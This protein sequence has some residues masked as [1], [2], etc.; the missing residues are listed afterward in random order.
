[1]TCLT[2]GAQFL[3]PAVGEPTR[4]ALKSRLS[5]DTITG[6][7]FLKKT[8][9]SRTLKRIMYWFPKQ[10]VIDGFLQISSFSVDLAYSGRG[11]GLQVHFPNPF[12]NLHLCCRGPCVKA[13]HTLEIPVTEA[14][15]ALGAVDLQTSRLLQE[16][17]HLSSPPN[18]GAG[19]GRHR[20][21]PTGQNPIATLFSFLKAT[22]LGDSEAGF[23]LSGGRAAP[24]SSR[25]PP[26]LT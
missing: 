21:S 14:T 15:R 26:C 11:T 12:P 13:E 3:F 17:Q 10:G 4:N 16:P 22:E 5:K 20:Q 7:H 23:P 9:I 19:G 25:C 2:P 18:K 8:T 1:M 24:S 6:S